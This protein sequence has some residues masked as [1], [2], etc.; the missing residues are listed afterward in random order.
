MLYNF[1]FRSPSGRWFEAAA[2]EETIKN[3]LIPSK[4][5][6]EPELKGVQTVFPNPLPPFLAAKQKAAA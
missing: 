5:N 4:G 3:L 1:K 2:S 6:P